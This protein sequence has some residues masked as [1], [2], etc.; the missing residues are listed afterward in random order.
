MISSRFPQL[1]GFPQLR[2]LLRLAKAP[3]L[4]LKE[5]AEREGVT[6]PTMSKAVDNLVEKGWATRATADD[7]RRSV[8]LTL[9]RAGAEL[10]HQVGEDLCKQLA[11]R[12]GVL[13]DRGL[14][15]LIEAMELLESAG[16]LGSGLEGEV[17]HA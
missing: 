2:I 8:Q 14:S 11:A 17:P 9:T 7:D 5:L 3:A 10:A 13:D 6:P 1:K 16:I 12:L 4:T 15:V